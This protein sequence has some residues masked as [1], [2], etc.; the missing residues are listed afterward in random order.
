MFVPAIDF[1]EL[2]G[3]QNE[4]SC[5]QLTWL[6]SQETSFKQTNLKYELSI[7]ED[8]VVINVLI[9]L[10]ISF[11]ESVWRWASNVIIEHFKNFFF[12]VENLFLGKFVFTDGKK[13]SEIWWV[14]FFVLS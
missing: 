8:L 2:F 4:S 10:S 1:L 7:E 3:R 9:Q 11:H 6:E 12:H 13:V 14:D 5:C